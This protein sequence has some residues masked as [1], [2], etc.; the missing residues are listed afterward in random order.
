MLES[1]LGS[2]VR[3][4]VLAALVTAPSEQMHLRALVRAAGGSVSSVQRE[5]ARLERLGVATS[6]RD[7][8]GRRQ[9]RLAEDHPFHG[10]LRD[11]VAAD[12]RAQY[13]ARVA[14][15][16]HLPSELVEELGGVVDAIVTGFDP[17]SIVLFGSQAEGSA[18]DR[19][20]I[21]LLVV[22]QAIEDDHKA[23]VALRSAAGDVSRGL[24]ILATDPARAEAA[25]DLQAS[26][27]R[28][29]LEEGFVLYERTA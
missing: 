23:A 19:S 2:A 29:A 15:L 21:D 1:L 7:A 24:D 11:L 5:V 25:R 10:P 22:L 26:V 4:R 17:V 20:D 27:V 12:P 3:S 13:G 8:G 9:V 28:D 18:D 16:A 14:S 6:S